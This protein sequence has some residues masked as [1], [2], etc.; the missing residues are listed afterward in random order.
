[1][2]HIEMRGPD[3]DMPDWVS[4]NVPMTIVEAQRT[5]D[6]WLKQDARVGEPYEYRIVPEAEGDAAK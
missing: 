1:M 5:V 4:I 6:R 2:H 3:M